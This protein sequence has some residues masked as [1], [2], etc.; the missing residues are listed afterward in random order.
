ML[1]FSLPENFDSPYKSQSMSE[2]W[3][4]WHMTLTRFFTKYVYFPLGGSRKGERRALLNILIV[5]LL[6][7]LWHG[8]N[9][10]FVV[11]GFVQG[12][13][14]AFCRIREKQAKAGMPSRFPLP[15]WAKTLAT[16]AYFILSLVFFRSESLL[17]AFHMFKH[18]FTPAWTGFLFELSGSFQ[19]SETYVIS[20]TLSLKAPAL[21]PWCQLA[22]FAL[23]L[24]SAI[25]LSSRKKAGEIILAQEKQGYSIKFCLL[26]AFLF[27]WSV[28]SLSKASPFL[29]FN[30]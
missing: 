7:G 25:F 23:W 11:W 16:M 13:A 18:L 8:A 20:Q 29:Y 5:F 27:S 3:R 4:R 17:V 6:S 12:L 30:F 28:I 14:V 2:F 9:W 1:G 24:G 21:L 22:L 19:L 10:T 15:D 26:L